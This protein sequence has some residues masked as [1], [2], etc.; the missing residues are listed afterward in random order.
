[1]SLD[2]VGGTRAVVEALEFKARSRG[3]DGQC[4]RCP[5]CLFSC[6]S[7]DPRPRQFGTGWLSHDWAVP[8]TVSAPN[9]NALVHYAVSSAL[10]SVWRVSIALPPH[11]LL[12]L[13]YRVVVLHFATR[14]VPMIRRG[15][16]DGSD[17]APNFWDGRSLGEEPTVS[18]N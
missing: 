9:V 14:I 8:K 1:M 11:L 16:E 3:A 2:G 13:I 7:A 4:Q 17:A 12:S 5:L 18:A 15:W 10:D 6:F